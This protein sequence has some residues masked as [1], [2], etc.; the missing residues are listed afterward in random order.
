METSS[1]ARLG[2]PPSGVA[3]GRPPKQ[4]HP[5]ETARTG[6]SENDNHGPSCYERAEGKRKGRP[7]V[8][9]QELRSIPAHMMVQWKEEFKSRSRVKCPSSGCWL[10]FPSIYGLKYHY[11]RCQGATVAE[12]LRHACPYCEAVFATKVRL[13]KHKLWNHPERVTMETKTESK[14]QVQKGPAKGN[15]KKRPMESG[16][17]SPMFIKVK[18]TQEPSQ[19]SQNGECTAT[20]TSTASTTSQ[21][22]DRKQQQQ[23]SQPHQQQQQ[24]QHTHSHTHMQTHTHMPPQQQEQ[25]Q[26]SSSDT[27][28]RTPGGSESDGGSLPP[29]CPEED[30]ERTRHKP[31]RKQK[32]PKKFTGEQPSISG[33]FGLKGMNKVEEKLKAGRAKRPEGGLFNEEPPRKLQAPA[34][35]RRE[36]PQ[37]PA[38]GPPADAQ[39]HSAIS[40]RGEVVC[41]T[42]S[43]VTRKTVSGLKKHMEICQ[44]LQD[45]LKC[46]Q[47]QKQFRS[48]AGLN[49]H[50]MAEH[51][52]KTT[53]NERRSG[54]GGGGGGGGSG[55]EERERLRRILKQ[56][57]KIKCPSEGCSAHFTSL[58]GYQYHQKRCGRD[59]SEAD[60]PAFQCQHCGKTYRSKAGRD[61]HLR[62]EHPV[63]QPRGVR[64][65]TMLKVA[66]EE[67]RPA[68]RKEQLPTEKT[69]EEAHRRQQ[70]QQQSARVKERPEERGGEQEDPAPP[71]ST[72][73]AMTTTTTG[74]P[75]AAAAA[76]MVGSVG[77]MMATAAAASMAD[78]VEDFERTPSGRVR[79]R[80]AQVAVFHLQEI[81][82]DELAKDWGTKRRIKD[83]LVPDSKRLNYTRPGLPTFDPEMLE[84]WKNQVKEKGF[85]CCPNGS[86][87]AVYSSV[88]GLKA[89]LANCT[90]AGG[91]VGKYMC[92]LC[93]KEFS[94]ESGVKY[95]IS[96]THSQNWFR[97]TTNI[98]PNN[99]KPPLPQSNGIKNEVKNGA[100]GKKRG[101]KPK[102]RP[103]EA[104]LSKTPS[105]NPPMS[106]PVQTQTQNQTSGLAQT[107]APALSP[108]NTTTTTPTHVPKPAPT[109]T[110]V[111]RGS[112]GQNRDT[113][114][115]MKKRGKPKKVPSVE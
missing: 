29:S 4:T 95:H 9:V 91:A 103:P 42:C 35:S 90:Q 22:P 31:G 73:T 61:Y 16:P 44:K 10:E 11:Q 58:M 110:P 1:G 65:G 96:K 6:S 82:E 79:R 75:A 21:R 102:E 83:D 107:T 14:G 63:T 72:A 81:A 70:Q 12:R 69:K 17:P 47:C 106:V 54:G 38:S 8:E 98:P 45:A 59:V 77:A 55:Q 5:P 105:S 97:A 33:T 27:S 88:S 13:Q 46:Q 26:A 60:K 28:P 64:A 113:Q 87:E 34:S 37:P 36:T 15:A 89:H 51:S 7:R 104:T 23:H 48:K 93:Q 114:P 32:T 85:I 115:L 57:G 99:K 94:S 20:A 56:M 111:D 62:S 68:G 53:G 76:S 84:T 67:P 49:Y 40:E 52:N 19:P 24:Q 41:P 92:L 101:R 71:L 43:V 78:S 80:S 18:K 3:K 25:E 39:W 112:L 109:P 108:T 30:P 74:A 100:T 2:K 50:T 66:T 86:C